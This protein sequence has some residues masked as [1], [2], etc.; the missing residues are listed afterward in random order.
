MSRH[1]DDQLVAYLDCEIE[2]AERRDIEAWLDSD[3]AARDKLTKLAMSATLLRDAYAEVLFIQR[4][5]RWFHAHHFLTTT[6][7]S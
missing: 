7:A 4:I 6:A 3:P 1:S 5:I 2:A